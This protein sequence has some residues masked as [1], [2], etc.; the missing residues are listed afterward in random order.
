ME[1]T[2]YMF[3]SSLGKCA[4][5]NFSLCANRWLIKVEERF[6]DVLVTVYNSSRGT[7]KEAI[8][9]VKRK[10]PEEEWCEY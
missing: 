7:L 2:V 1:K 6:N 9:A 5:L 4:M 10:F 3:E 8:D